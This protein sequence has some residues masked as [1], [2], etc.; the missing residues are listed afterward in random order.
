MNKNLKWIVYGD[1]FNSREIVKYN[2]FDH[3]SFVED[4]Y[5]IKKKFKN[6]FESFSKEVKRSLMYYFWSKCE[7]EVI[8]T[9]WP[10]SFVTQKS[11]ED[12]KETPSGRVDGVQLEKGIK[13]DI[14][15]QVG[16]NW[17]AFIN[18]LWNNLSTPTRKKSKVT[19]KKENEKGTE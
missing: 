19:L 13:V 17:D 6:D 11:I 18:Y 1:D 3:M 10:T 9:D 16:L 12:I 5:K 7:Y 2:I 14:Y 8:I 4:V 15:D